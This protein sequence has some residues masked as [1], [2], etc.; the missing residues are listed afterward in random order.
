MKLKN[1]EKRLLA[2]LGVTVI[3]YLLL[4]YGI[5]PTLDKNALIQSQYD[6]VNNEY[7]ALKKSQLTNNQLKEV[8][9]RAS[10][11]YQ[12]LE[13]LLPPQIHQEEAILYLTDLAKKHEMTVDAYNF[14][15]SEVAEVKAVTAEGEPVVEMA[16]V[17]QV[18]SEFQK[19][20]NGDQ[21]A[22]LQQY[23]DKIYQA[24]AEE[25][26]L[27]ETYEK[28]LKY[29]NVSITL[30]GNYTKFKNYVSALEAYDHKIIIKQ[31]NL[32]KDT[33]KTDVVIG[34]LSI[35]YPIYYDEEE[36]KPYDWTYA[37]EAVNANPFDYKVFTLDTVE[38]VTTGTGVI[39]GGNGTS[40][41]AVTGT[42]GPKPTGNTV[43]YTSPDFY[44]VLKPANSD[45][46]TLTIGKSPYR[47]TALYADNEG[48]ETS[49][50]K[51]RKSD[52]KYQYQYG[53]SLQTYPGDTDWNDFDPAQKGTLILEVHSAL[54]LPAN[55]N[56]GVLLSISNDSGLPLSVYLYSE[57]ASRPRLT[58]NKVSG[59]VSVIKQ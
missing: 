39:T 59:K 55:D 48:V 42:T 32:T 53:T 22:D 20:I 34:A 26:N 37:K 29:L 25:A 13:K 44:M 33:E 3:A 19:M 17:D 43:N 1:S 21:S 56:A 46:N 45:A 16:P 36:L 8:L 50:L 23:K 2:I 58:I 7:Q 54:R 5:F 10:S 18:L 31:I 57:D 47:Y 12:S 24:P 30:K 14:S 41:T 49:T 27:M 6:L 4:T 40:S 52:G 51:I 11:Q 28:D 9:N 15:F 35:S 38:P